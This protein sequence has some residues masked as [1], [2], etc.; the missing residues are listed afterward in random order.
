MWNGQLWSN[1]ARGFG[2]FPRTA[3]VR[4]T[5]LKTLKMR[6][7]QQLMAFGARERVKALRNGK[8]RFLGKS[9]LFG[10]IPVLSALFYGCAYEL[11]L[12]WYAVFRRVS[13]RR[14]AA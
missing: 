7:R 4:G 9:G 3:E 2:P 1:Y 8:G 5:T 13:G 12:P 11:K 10:I 6:D 14:S